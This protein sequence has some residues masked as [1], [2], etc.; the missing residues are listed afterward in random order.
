M[1]TMPP[2]TTKEE[3]QKIADNTPY[4]WETCIGCGKSEKDYFIETGFN[5]LTW[6][7]EPNVMCCEYCIGDYEEDQS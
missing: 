2:P 4:Q 7:P 5:M 3:R 1:N 6:H